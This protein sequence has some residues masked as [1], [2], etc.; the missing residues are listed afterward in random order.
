VV[1]VLESPHDDE[2]D[3][4]NGQFSPKEPLM[5]EGS[6][7]RLRCHLVRLALA[8]AREKNVALSDDVDIVLCNPIQFQTSLHRLIRP[9]QNGNK[10]DLRQGIRNATWKGLWN[11]KNGS[12]YPFRNE[13]KK[14]LREFAPCL[15]INASTC[16]LRSHL[17][18]FF[19]GMPALNVVEVT[20]HPSRWDCDTDL[21]TCGDFSGS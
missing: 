2:Y 13:F 16:V 21:G 8:A 3:Y 5:D 15:V 12:S 1:V 20:N 19:E 4:A 11:Y 7:K 18:T 17:R 9:E 14:R 10:G 6:Q